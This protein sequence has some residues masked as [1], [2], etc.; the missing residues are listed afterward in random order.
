MKHL[1]PLMMVIV[2]TGGQRLPVEKTKR[3]PLQKKQVTLQS[4]REY[5]KRVLRVDAKTGEQIL[6]DPKPRI[7]LMD[8]KSGKYYLK[9]IGYDG[10]EKVVIYQRPDA[11][12]VI[13]S[14][15]VVRNSTGQFVYQYTAQ[16]LP[17]SGEY[18]GNFMV[19]TLT[20][21]IIP[22]TL[23]TQIDNIFIGRMS[24][25]IF[26]EGK[27]INFAPLP[28]R[29]RVNPGQS[30]TFQLTSSS[31][32]GL[33]M[34]RVNGGDW[35][36]NGAGEEMP[37]ELENALPN[38]YRALPSGYTI[39]PINNLKALSAVERANYLLKLLPKFKELGW[40]TADALPWYQQT[41][42]GNLLGAVYERTKQDLKEGNIT[43]EV[44]AMIQAIKE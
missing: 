19:Q 17:T 31:P 44:F 42:S 9:W 4:P 33:V 25:N 15:S 27:W 20:S 28:P 1:L 21:D 38:R 32:P 6:Y 12:D 3:L 18:L 41:L 37:W 7:A 26:E 39:G 24:D 43:T 34:C 14:A 23:P 35:G 2:A 16:N 5:L 36:M 22:N 8:A 11:V 29:P 40:I 13:V 30:I 10:K